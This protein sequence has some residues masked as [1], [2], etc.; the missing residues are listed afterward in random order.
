MVITKDDR[1]A[2]RT[3]CGQG[4]GAFAP[5]VSVA[6]LTA[7]LD[8]ADILARLRR[9]EYLIASEYRAHHGTSLEVEIERVLGPRP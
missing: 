2:L 5:A 4:A 9:Y 1:I 6:A 8:A 3:L 7:L